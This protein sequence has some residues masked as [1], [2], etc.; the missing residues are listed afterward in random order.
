M[1]ILA[2]IPIGVPHMGFIQSSIGTERTLTILTALCPA[3]YAG[4]ASADECD[5]NPMAGVSFRIGR[6]FTDAFSDYVPTNTEGL[7]AFEF[8]GLPLDGTLRI[9]EELPADT[10]RFVV[11]C[12]DEAGNAFGITYPDY[13]ETNP[14]LGVADVAV[15]EVG[16]VACDWYNVP[17]SSIAD[18]SEGAEVG[19]VGEPSWWIVPFAS[20][21]GNTDE[22]QL[23]FG[24]LVENPTN[25]TIYVGA[26]FRA[27]EADGTPFPGCHMPSSEGPG[28]STTI[29]PGETALLTCSR[30]IVPRTLDGLQVTARLW[31]IQPVAIPPLDIAVTEA[32]FAPLPE[33]STPMETTY[34]A[35]ALVHAA[36]N[37]D[38]DARLLFRFYDE[39]GVQVGTCE[40][41]AVTIEPEVEQ[42]VGCSFPLRLDTV[43]PQP[44]DVR[45]EAFS[46]DIADI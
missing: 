14:G 41:D 43:S 13:T 46:A 32:D 34:N 23:Y 42:R 40:S 28:V 2:I 12:V 31:D 8:D 45:V 27:Y 3:G 24:A 36:G 16:D 19:V 39:Q 35:S 38:T 7:V 11:Y 21:Y 1:I 20:G 37:Q 29:A 17:V 10:E 4:D 33:Q 5:A 9:I 18:E 30:T 25:A 6:P 15:G 22:G 26:S 44:V